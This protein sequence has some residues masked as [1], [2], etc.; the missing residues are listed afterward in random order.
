MWRS[1]DVTDSRSFLDRVHCPALVLSG[2][3]DIAIPR[4]WSARAAERLS[5][6]RLI[7]IDGA[8]TTI[9]VTHGAEAR[10]AILDLIRGL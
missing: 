8:G 4:E 5:N 6:G 9:P 7:E 2:T 3:V 10:A 1:V